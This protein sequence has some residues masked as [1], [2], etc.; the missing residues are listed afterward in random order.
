MTPKRTPEE[1]IRA[2]EEESPDEDIERVLSM[3]DDEIR[4]ELEG[5]GYTRAELD[6]KTAAIVG[7][8]PTA[9]ASGPAIGGNA[10]VDVSRGEF[11][12]GSGAEDRGKA[13]NVTS[14]ARR[15]RA[16]VWVPLSIAAAAALGVGLARQ[17]GLFGEESVGSAGESADKEKR[18]HAEVLRSEAAEALEA[19]EWTKVLAL[20]DEAKALDPRGDDA[21]GVA[22]ARRIARRKL[23]LKDTDR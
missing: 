15:F 4:K 7:L 14:I 8:A 1:T 12:S 5:A 16:R 3:S 20:L 19:G 6:A 21:P 18:G 23:G 17:A 22:D 10:K 9:K 13:S 11:V 2:I